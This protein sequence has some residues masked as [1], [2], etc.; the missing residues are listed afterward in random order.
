MTKGDAMVVVIALGLVAGAITTVAG[1][2]GGLVL[3]LAL[4]SIHDPV[5]ALAAAGI[6]LLVGNV[7]R[8]WMYRR[9]VVRPTAIPYVLGAVP[10][11][12]LGGLVA[13]AAP[14]DLVRG[15]MLVIAGLAAA[16]TALGVRWKAPPGAM[17]PGGVAVGFVSATSGGGGLLAGPLLL[18]TGLSGRAYVA[19]GAV[20]A[21]SVHVARLTGYGA[22]G[23]LDGSVLVLGA[24]LAACIPLG[25]LIGDRT[26]RLI[27]EAWVPRLEIGVVVAGLA[28][29]VVGM[30]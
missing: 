25:N 22:G 8:V 13:T 27:P 21:V 23:A 19:T 30:L 28:L 14:E 10:G 12:L 5:V 20:G 11:A 3:T 2:G 4:A 24:V 29:A 26:R 18:A 16:K 15:A 7:H 9:R 1:M 17:L 6:G